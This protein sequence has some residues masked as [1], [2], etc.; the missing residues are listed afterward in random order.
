MGIIR[1]LAM[2]PEEM[3]GLR[4]LPSGAAWMSCHF[5]G[6]GLGDLP[7]ELPPGTLLILDDSVPMEGQNPETILNLLSRYVREKN[8]QALLLDFQRKDSRQEA[9]LAQL[10]QKEL[11]CPVGISEPY[12]DKAREGPVFLPLLPPH[13]KLSDYLRPWKDREVWL[14]I[15]PSPET[16]CV[17]SKGTDFSG[18]EDTSQDC[19]L[20]CEALSCHYGCEIKEDRILFHLRRDAGDLQALLKSAE[21][22]G[23]TRAIGLYQELKP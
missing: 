2:A 20:S 16:A 23:V 9:E 8:C 3:S 18:W 21:A 5:S 17:T 7:P 11:P 4:P 1:N 19:P 10:L 12:A 14:E 22:L 13:R 6:E 15:G